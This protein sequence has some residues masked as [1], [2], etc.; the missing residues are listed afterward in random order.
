MKG[1]SDGKE[2]ELASDMKRITRSTAK[3]MIQKGSN[4]K[5]SQTKSCRRSL[6]FTDDEDGDDAK[7]V[8]KEAPVDQP[9]RSQA[10]ISQAKRNQLLDSMRKI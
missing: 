10:K 3:L 7:D 6:C 5:P 8:R 4:T 9:K 2:M 1:S